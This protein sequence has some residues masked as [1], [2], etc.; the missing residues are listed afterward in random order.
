MGSC[1]LAGHLDQV[2]EINTLSTKDVFM[3]TNTW[4]HFL[5]QKIPV[6]AVVTSI[7]LPRTVKLL[8]HAQYQQL[9]VLITE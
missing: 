8:S 2:E 6:A 3:D 1:D 9:N 5:F 4:N 7:C